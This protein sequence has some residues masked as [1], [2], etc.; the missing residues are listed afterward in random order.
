MA[1]SYHGLVLSS[2]ALCNPGSCWDL[3]EV[4]LYWA[5]LLIKASR[6]R[7]GVLCPEAGCWL[8]AWGSRG[9][10]ILCLRLPA[11]AEACA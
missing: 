5:S 1:Y 11:V 7:S 4:I 9:G 3:R 2:M 6:S 10:A 8:T